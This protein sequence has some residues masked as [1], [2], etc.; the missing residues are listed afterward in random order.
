MITTTIKGMELQFQTES[1]LFSPRRIDKGTLA[2][3]S[4]IEFDPEDRVCDLGCGYGVVGITAAKLIGPDRVLMIDNDPEAA[5]CA[6]EN[7]RLNGVP[8]AE[9]IVSDGF[10]ATRETH[11]TKIITHPPYH[12][13]FSVPKRFIEKGFNRLARE[14]QFYMVTKRKEWYKQKL[15]SIFGGVS[16]REVEGY[17]VFM[18][19]KKNGS[20]ACAKA[21]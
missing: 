5:S 16:I 2:L 15:I 20:Y 21:R 3:L 14:G 12:A 13:D 9:V 18:A 7:A 11:F 4:A 10:S 8:E 17:Y 1:S 19:V 6:R